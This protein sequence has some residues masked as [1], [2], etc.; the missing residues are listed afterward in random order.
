MTKKPPFDGSVWM[1]LLLE[2]G[3]IIVAIAMAF[4]GLDKRLAVIESQMRIA[5]EAQKDWATKAAL[6]TLERRVDRLE[7]RR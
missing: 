2:V 7:A 6:D 1:R 4:G 3:I 5:T